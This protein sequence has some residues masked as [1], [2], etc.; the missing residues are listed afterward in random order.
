MTNTKTQNNYAIKEYTPADNL[1]YQ[2]EIKDITISKLV[3][4]IEELE[5]EVEELKKPKSEVVRHVG[6]NPTMMEVSIKHYD[7]YFKTDRSKRSM[8]I[9][10]TAI[11]GFVNN[12]DLKNPDHYL[13]YLIADKQLR[14]IKNGKDYVMVIELITKMES[15][16]YLFQPENYTQSVNK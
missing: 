7:S 13:L 12:N 1:K 15:D 10:S 9:I 6:Y 2:L 14:S 5:N 4:E 3:K 11:N 8:Y 16:L